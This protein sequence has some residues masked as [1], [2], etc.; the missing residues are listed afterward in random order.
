M[1]AQSLCS[2][3]KID[4]LSISNLIESGEVQDITDVLTRTSPQ[5]L[6]LANTTQ[7]LVDSLPLEEKTKHYFVHE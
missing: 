3:Y 6:G 2:D 5:S 1:S 4:S 7:H